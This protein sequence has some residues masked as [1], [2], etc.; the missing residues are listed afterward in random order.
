MSGVVT[1]DVLAAAGIAALGGLAGLTAGIAAGVIVGVRY[2]DHLSKLVSR[3]WSEATRRRI[4]REPTVPLTDSART[5]VAAEF[6][7]HA[8]SVQS[9][10]SRFADELAAGDPVLRARLRRFEQPQPSGEDR[11][12]SPWSGSQWSGWSA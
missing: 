6:A 10:V 2:A 5:A 7:A 11:K 12:S 4:R 9:Q 3:G 8:A 1:A